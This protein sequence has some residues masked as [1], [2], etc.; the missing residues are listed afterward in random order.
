M[1]DAKPPINYKAL[2]WTAGVHV[3]LLLLFALWKFS[4]PAAAAPIAE[5][6]MEVNLGTSADGFGTDQ[7][8]DMEEP[9]A[10]TATANTQT[11]FAATASERQ[12]EESD[13]ADAPAV[14]TAKPIVKPVRPT[15]QTPK[16]ITNNRQMN[17]QTSPANT[18]ITAPQRPK[19]TYQGS[20]GR[21]GNGAVQNSPGTNEG[22]TTGNGD[23]GVPHGT[24]GATNYTGSP[25]NGTGGISYTLAGR[26][27]IAFPM[28]EAEF[29]EGG[30]VVVRVTVN[31]AGT[32]V[33]K[34][35]VSATN[36][37]LRPI[38]LKKLNQVKFNQN[39]NAPA[40]QFG[41]ITFVFKTRN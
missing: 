11:Q 36:A 21:G 2:S 22:N 18:R 7:P 14:A 4:A 16:P 5:M 30:K 9:A 26:S 24:P 28:N 35:V 3:V 39:E 41:N 25:G 1:E 31:R 38:A 6:G 40:E 23:R 37:E 10:A 29:R 12:V 32:I 34:Q 19:Y 13:E 33:N 17:T 15:L 8:M 27:M 20:T